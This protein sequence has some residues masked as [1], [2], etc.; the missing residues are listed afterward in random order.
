M[1]E[2]RHTTGKLDAARCADTG[3]NPSFDNKLFKDLDPED[4]VN[5][6]VLLRRLVCLKFIHYYF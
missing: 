3:L 6:R 4:Y 2:Q 5:F 1:R